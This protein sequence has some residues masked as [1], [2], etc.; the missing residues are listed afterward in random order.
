MVPVKKPVLVVFAGPNGAGK[1]TMYKAR[2]SRNS[3]FPFINADVIQKEE[4]RDPDES[5]SYQAAAIAAGRRLEHIEQGRSFIT[6]TVFSHPSKLDL[7]KNARA[8]GFEIRLFHISVEDPEILVDRVRQRVAEGG[9]NVPEHKIRERYERN[10][11]L[12]RQAVLHSDTA[13]VYDNSR[14]NRSPEMMLSFKESKPE[15]RNSKISQWVDDLY[16]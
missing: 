15:F 16:H 4:L 8:R 10:G 7:I 2:M 14:F 13:R 6:E 3:T 9:H 5:A 1:T 11:P 12:I